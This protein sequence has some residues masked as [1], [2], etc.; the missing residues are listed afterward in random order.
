MNIELKQAAQQ[1]AEAID[2]MLNVIRRDAPQIS[3]K[4]MGN[5]EKCA[6]D[7]RAAIQQAAESEPAAA[8]VRY[9]R[10]RTPAHCAFDKKDHYSEWSDWVPCTLSYAKAVTDPNRDAGLLPLYEMLP[11]YTHPAPSVSDGWA[12]VKRNAIESA[13]Q[14]VP[15][16][17]ETWSALNAAM[18]VT[19]D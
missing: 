11:L 12:V 2:W 13:L 16:R 6:T 4:A 15:Y 7:L 17:G 1:A 3:G 19:P 10:V 14:H 5:A 8:L 9:R 18:L